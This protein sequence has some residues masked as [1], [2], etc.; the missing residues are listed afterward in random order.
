MH[1][2]VG[3]KDK[4]CIRMRVYGME[5]D[6]TDDIFAEQQWRGRLRKQTC[7]LNAGRKGCDEL[8]EWLGSMYITICKINSK[9]G[10]AV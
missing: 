2:E 5:K 7:G 3:Q 8:R 10:F 1:S 9:W 6:S 4:Y